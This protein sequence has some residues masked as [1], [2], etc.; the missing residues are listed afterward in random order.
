MQAACQHVA[1]AFQDLVTA[2]TLGVDNTPPVGTP[3]ARDQRVVWK[4]PEFIRLLKLYGRVTVATLEYSIPELRR[5]F[6]DPICWQRLHLELLMEVI[7]DNVRRLHDTWCNAAIVGVRPFVPGPLVR[8]T[9][10]PRA[11]LTNV[12][13]DSLG[14]MGCSS[15]GSA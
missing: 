13:I 10:T 3:K 6:P 14:T 4:F 2:M 8:L 7:I 5:Q 11:D 9:V 1:T 15:K 12:T